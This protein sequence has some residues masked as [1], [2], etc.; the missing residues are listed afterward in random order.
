MKLL[1]SPQSCKFHRIQN[2][3]QDNHKKIY[4]NLLLYILADR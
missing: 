2:N 3:L 1:I 4:Q